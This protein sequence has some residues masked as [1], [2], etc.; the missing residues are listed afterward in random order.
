MED[1]NYWERLEVLGNDSY[2]YK[3]EMGGQ[4][5]SFDTMFFCGGRGRE[6]RRA[7]TQD[8]GGPRWSL[9]P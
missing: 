7:S 1:M 3:D 8:S 9:M 5:D 2:G 4:P 6:F